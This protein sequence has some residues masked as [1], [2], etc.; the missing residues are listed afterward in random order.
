M[1]RGF[2]GRFV[3]LAND[4]QVV[5]QTELNRFYLIDHR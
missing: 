5:V 2:W 4:M 1:R 3:N